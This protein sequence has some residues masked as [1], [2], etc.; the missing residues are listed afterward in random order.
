MMN[1]FYRE[2]ERKR[3]LSMMNDLKF[4]LLKSFLEKLDIIKRQQMM[5]VKLCVIVFVY[6]YV[7]R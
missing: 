4:L 5:K 2:N 1:K 6:D 7:C 3:T